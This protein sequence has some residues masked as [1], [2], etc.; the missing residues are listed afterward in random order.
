[1]QASEYYTALNNITIYNYTRQDK[2]Y[3]IGPKNVYNYVALNARPIYDVFDTRSCDSCDVGDGVSGSFGIGPGSQWF[4]QTLSVDIEFT[5]FFENGFNEQF[6]LMGNQST[7]SDEEKLTNWMDPNN[8]Y[9]LYIGQ[10]N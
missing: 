3:L 10:Y 7:F 4:N 1:M 5:A 2:S 6:I 9:S 8:Q